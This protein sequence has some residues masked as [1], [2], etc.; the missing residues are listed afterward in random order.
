[1]PNVFIGLVAFLCLLGTSD[2][3]AHKVKLFAIAEGLQIKG[4][5]Y[6]VSGKRIPHLP[7]TVQDK[8]GKLLG[9]TKTNAQGIFH[10]TAMHPIEHQFNVQTVE[11]DQARYILTAAELQT[12]TDVSSI[13]AGDTL[14]APHKTKQTGCNLALENML[15]RAIRPL[16]EQL[17]AYQTKI[18]LHDLIGGVG[19]IFGIM[20]LIL[21]LNQRGK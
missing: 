16:R 4:Y 13:L 14:I 2:V 19:Y 18:W 7:V 1:M 11:G 8:Q 10:Y 9:K 21:Y 12:T 6:F 20:G 17:D 3:Y 5:V 15:N